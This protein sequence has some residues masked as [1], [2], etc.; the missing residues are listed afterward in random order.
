MPKAISDLPT[1]IRATTAMT[2]SG[3]RSRID[4]SNSMPTDTKNSTAKASCNGIE[5]AAAL[6][7]KRDSFSTT[8]AKKAPS[9]KDTPNSTAEP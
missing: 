4:G 9:A 2:A 1:T 6:W 8:P 3:S 5:S 7:L